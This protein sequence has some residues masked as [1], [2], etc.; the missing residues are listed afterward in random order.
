MIGL[1]GKKVGMTVVYEEDGTQ[2]PVTL[3]LAGPC[4]VL[5]I[6][7]KEKSGY[8]AVQLGFGVRKQKNVTR[9]VLGQF[10]KLGL[11]ALAF[12]REIRTE[13]VEGL[14]VGTELRVDNFE[15]GEF[16]DIEGVS[17][18]KGFQ[19]ESGY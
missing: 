6:L 5:R 8:S 3:L 14:E 10:R 13:E 17:I 1:L 2:T 15:A 16:V 12:V 9:P 19:G 7:K 11:P 18:G 4:R